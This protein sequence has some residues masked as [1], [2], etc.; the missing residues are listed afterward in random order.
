MR[1]ACGIRS[2]A[3]SRS[4]QPGSALAEAALKEG[5]QSHGIIDCATPSEVGIRGP[6]FRALATGEP[7]LPGLE[8]PEVLT[9]FRAAMESEPVLRDLV[10]IAG[11]PDVHLTGPE[12]VVALAVADGLD[13]DGFAGDDGRVTSAWNA[14]PVIVTRV[15]S[16]TVR[17]ERVYSDRLRQ[18]LLQELHDGTRVGDA[19]RRSASG[20]ARSQRQSPSR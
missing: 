17:V 12:V 18:A 9:A 14:D 7:W 13:R 19:S 1:C 15:D 11:D 3:H 20:L 5:T 2:R 8:D 6:A 16:L 4:R 10:L